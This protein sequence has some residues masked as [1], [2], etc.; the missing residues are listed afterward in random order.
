MKGSKRKCECQ[1]EN[2]EVKKKI[3]EEGKLEGGKNEVGERR[4]GRK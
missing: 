3:E 4:N 1:Q 2:N